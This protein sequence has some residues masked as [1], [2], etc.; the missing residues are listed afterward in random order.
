MVS[1][2]SIL[3]LNVKIANDFF[4]LVQGTNFCTWSL[5]LSDMEPRSYGST[6]AVEK[7]SSSPRSILSTLL[8][9]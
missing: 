7:A 9:C 2:K 3:G 1:T 6:K 8:P 4:N 5:E